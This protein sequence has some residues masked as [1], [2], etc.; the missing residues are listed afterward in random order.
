VLREI[1]RALQREDREGRNVLFPLA[2][3]DYL[4]DQWRHPR[5]ADVLSKVV[6]DF[7]VWD[8]GVE[9]YRLSFEKPLMA[10]RA[11]NAPSIQKS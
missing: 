6:G 5:K 10:L 11:E 4:F 3:D 9:K 7:R 1:E 2:I 8:Q